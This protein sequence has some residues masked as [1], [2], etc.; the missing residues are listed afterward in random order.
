MF[1]FSAEFFRFRALLGLYPKK[2]MLHHEQY[3]KPQTELKCRF[4]V[5]KNKPWIMSS[6]LKRRHDLGVFSS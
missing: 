3:K 2:H 4:R 1:S 5:I 6:E